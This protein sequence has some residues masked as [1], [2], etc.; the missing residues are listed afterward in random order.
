MSSS[1]PTTQV[2]LT[3]H[4]ADEVAEVFVFD[5][6]FRLVAHGSGTVQFPLDP[7][8]YKVRVSTANATAEK[9]VILR[10]GDQRALVEFPHLVYASP[11][12][13]DDTA[14]LRDYHQAAAQEASTTPHRRIGQG[15][16]IFVFARDYAAPQPAS[17]QPE[18]PYPHPAQGL[19]LEDGQGQLLVDLSKEGTH[20][21][22]NASQDPWAACNVA[23]NPGTYRLVLQL[24]TGET[25][26]QPLVASPGWQTQVFLLQRTYGGPD[27]RRADLPGAAILLTRLGAGFHPGSPDLRLADLARAGLANQRQVLSDQLRVMLA[28]DHENPA[29]GLSGA[30]LLL[31]DKAPNLDLLGAAVQHLRTL[32]GTHPD[33]EAL[34][35]RVHG[36]G[37]YV[38]T[39]PPMLLPSWWL[40]VGA[41][42]TAPALVPIDS[43]A[44]Q[45]APRQWGDG[46]WFLWMDPPDQASRELGLESAFSPQDAFADALKGYLL[47]GGSR[48]G[49]IPE[50]AGGDPSSR[51]LGPDVGSLPTQLD[52]ATA[53]RLVPVLNLPRGNIQ[54][55][56][57]KLH[58]QPAP[59]GP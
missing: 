41:S 37:S 46:P 12:P 43:L 21:L 4:P 25:L 33:V 13:L 54:A 44:G 26:E 56:L 59:E 15:S 52:D 1:N 18:T 29:L 40:I 48:G 45:V 35:L 11:A 57:D 39:G 27:T 36:P 3:I 5:G 53:R 55:L 47:P 38:F 10:S 14:C 42:T 2:A 23:V 30:H 58:Q 31:L 20:N 17:N 19:I 49:L 8:I 7:G 22:D 9:H 51:D 6:Q 32:L 16:S 34:D 28:G 50:S 24:P